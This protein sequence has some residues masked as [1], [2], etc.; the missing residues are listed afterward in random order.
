MLCADRVPNKRTHFGSGALTQAGSPDPRN[1]RI[2]ITCCS[3][4]R[5]FVAPD[6][7]CNLDFVTPRERGGAASRG[8]SL[9]GINARASFTNAVVNM[10]PVPIKNPRRESIKKSSEMAHASGGDRPICCPRGPHRCTT[11]ADRGLVG[12]TVRSSPDARKTVASHS[13][14]SI[15]CDVFASEA[16]RASRPEPVSSNWPT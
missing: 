3:P 7:R 11:V 10:P 16:E 6:L 2:C 15:V 8:A 1:D 14:R 4:S 12:E 5:P 13:E 9:R